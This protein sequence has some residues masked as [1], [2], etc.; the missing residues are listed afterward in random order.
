[1]VSVLQKFHTCISWGCFRLFPPACFLPLAIMYC[2]CLLEMSLFWNSQCLSFCRIYNLHSK[3]QAQM[4]SILLHT[5][6]LVYF[7]KN[8]TTSLWEDLGVLA[9]R[10][11]CIQWLNQKWS[12]NV[13]RLTFMGTVFKSHA[14]VQTFSGFLS[15]MALTVF[16]ILLVS[17]AVSCLA[18]KNS[19]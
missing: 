6:E 19:P 11:S 1:M 9:D 18:R 5:L 12:L 4:L 15:I 16:A 2:C 14:Y 7:P 8:P 10:V 17:S 3:K 13:F